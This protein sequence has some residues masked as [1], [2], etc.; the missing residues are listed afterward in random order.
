MPTP[1]PGP[2][3]GRHVGCLD[4]AGPAPRDVREAEVEC[5]HAAPLR[6]DRACDMVKP[7][8]GERRKVQRHGEE[9]HEVERAVDLEVPGVRNEVEALLIQ[10]PLN[11]SSFTQ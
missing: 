4:G 10:S 11:L 9:V 7:R 5:V 3:R 2:R 8:G 1:A 6:L